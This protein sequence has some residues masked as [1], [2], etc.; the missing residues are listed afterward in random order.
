VKVT[1]VSG[2][3]TTLEA[4]GVATE[5][6]PEELRQ[7]YSQVK[8]KGPG[9]HILTGP[10]WIEGAHSRDILE[11]EILD[12]AP[13][14]PYGHNTFS[15]GQGSLPED[16]PYQRTR[17]IKLNLLEKFAHFNQN[18]NLPINPFFGQLGIAPPIS[19]GRLTSREP[20]FHGGNLDNKELTVGAKIYLPIHVQGALF[21]VGDGHCLQGDGEADVT[22]LEACMQGTLKFTIRKDLHLRWPMA[23]TRNHIISMGFHED[24]DEAA[25][26]ALRNMIDYI[27][28]QGLDRDDAYSL[29]S[30]IVDLHVTQL[31]NGV[32][33]IHGLLSKEVL[34]RRH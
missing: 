1:T 20:G 24:L 31:V 32:K 5:D 27:V 9:P 26:M 18:I 34:K 4:L 2:D 25:K 16:Y 30:L 21:S 10:I 19:L 8:E 3:P 17:I 14:Y 15:P 23:E 12:I 22:A 13:T 7:I 11:V 6:I 29:S 33:G 28:Q